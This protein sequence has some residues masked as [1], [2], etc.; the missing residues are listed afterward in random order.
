[1]KM[2]MRDDSRGCCCGWLF[3]IID[4]TQPF[5]MPSSILYKQFLQRQSPLSLRF[6]LKISPTTVV[7]GGT[8]S[9]YYCNDLPTTRGH[10]SPE[11]RQRP[12]S[13]SYTSAGCL[14]S[15]RRYHHHHHQSLGVPSSI[16]SFVRDDCDEDTFLIIPKHQRIE[17]Y[18]PF[19]PTY[20]ST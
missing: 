14:I 7:G 11:G 15:P 16:S 3:E 18:T 8:V 17:N 2:T 12:S 1:M 19:I 5:Q 20:S 10:P 9:Q 6:Y 4:N 13:T